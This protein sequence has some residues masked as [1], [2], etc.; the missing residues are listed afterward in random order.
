MIKTDKKN[1]AVLHRLRRIGHFTQSINQISMRSMTGA[2]VFAHN[3]TGSVEINWG[4]KRAPPGTRAHSR[5]VVGIG[6]EHDKVNLRGGEDHVLLEENDDFE[7]R[8][9]KIINITVSH[10][11]SFAFRSGHPSPVSPNESLTCGNANKSFEQCVRYVVNKR[12]RYFLLNVR[13]FTKRLLP[14]FHL[15][16]RPQ[17]PDRNDSGGGQRVE[18]RVIACHIDSEFR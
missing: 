16:I 14:L 1:V 17:L 6:A 13:C 10:L 3:T 7:F 9:G 15:P 12:S 5:L 11:P 8:K 18:A 2:R 4:Q